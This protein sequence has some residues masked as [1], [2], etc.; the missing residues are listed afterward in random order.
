MFDDIFREPSK[1][2]DKVLVV[3]G[4]WFGGTS[5]NGIGITEI[6]FIQSE[7]RINEVLSVGMS[8]NVVM[9]ITHVIQH[10]IIDNIVIRE[11]K[12]IIKR[13]SSGS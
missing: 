9:Q 12:C 11:G 4:R 2:R 1:T 7:V 8:H 3:D 5:T 6:W 10:G 13:E